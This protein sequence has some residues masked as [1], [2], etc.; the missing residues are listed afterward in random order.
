M[1]KEVIIYQYENGENNCWG[2][3]G[4]FIYKENIFH[5]KN[6][7]TISL[8][9]V[10]KTS[11]DGDLTLEQAYNWV[12]TQFDMVKKCTG[13]KINMYKTGWV[14]STI[15]YLI[16][17]EQL[18]KG[19][20]AEPIGAEE[21]KWLD[22]A[23]MGAYHY[24]T[25][26]TYE[27]VYSYDQKSSYPFCL[28]H[29]DFHI[30][31]KKGIF[32]YLEPSKFYTKGGRLTCG[33]Y[34]AEVGGDNVHF[35]YNKAGYYTNWQLKLALKLDLPITLEDTNPNMMLYPIKKLN[36]PSFAPHSINGSFLLQDYIKYFY[37]L[38]SKYGKQCPMFKSL[39][40]QA[41]GALSQRKEQTEYVIKR[42]LRDGKYF[43]D[44]Q[45]II[46]NKN[47]TITHTLPWDKETI[48]LKTVNTNDVY[49]SN[50]AR[51]KPFLLDFQRLQMYERVILPY[52]D[53]IIYLNTDGFYSKVPIQ[54]FDA[55]PPELG[56]FCLD[57]K[58]SK[59]KI[60]NANEVEKT[61]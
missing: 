21:Y 23:I 59:V 61:S 18:E 6:G 20:V 28:Q 32:S 26:G 57:Q 37:Q 55:N 49:I 27:N 45:Y 24:A 16:K 41:W 22:G 9:K 4:S 40:S 5:Y 44:Y 36:N 54:E 46:D 35:K 10:W 48:H 8:N 50:L 1:E 60:I 52:W 38:K 43:F 14:P 7:V 13:G 34:R 2:K 31:I 33:I 42:Q 11:G 29:G 47:I 19:V 30:P 25:K 39:L 58:Y 56:R 12:T 51:L 53:N 15:R 17:Q 3:S